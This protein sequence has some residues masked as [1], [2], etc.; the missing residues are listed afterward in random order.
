M[1]PFIPR[2][3]EQNMG[4]CTQ[5]KVRFPRHAFKMSEAVYK[6]IWMHPKCS[7]IDQ[8]PCIILTNSNE[9]FSRRRTDKSF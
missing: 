6:P 9:F 4:K 1:F 8:L 5:Y 2:K 3:V 7:E